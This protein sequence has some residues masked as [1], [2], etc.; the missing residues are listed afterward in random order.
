MNER[1]EDKIYFSNGKDTKVKGTEIVN[2][3]LQTNM[4][5]KLSKDVIAS[6]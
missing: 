3:L 1:N 2:I 5:L 4:I 6:A